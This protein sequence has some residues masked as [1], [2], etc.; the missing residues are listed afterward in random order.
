MDNT[1]L[2]NILNTC[3][4]VSLSFAILFFIITVILFFVFDIKTI[5]DI[6]TGRA[7]SKTVSEMKKANA[8]TGRLRVGGKTVTSKLSEED[9]RKSRTPA[10][11]PPDN[12]NQVVE[13]YD[14]GAAQTDVLKPEQ[15][16][17]AYTSKVT[18]IE[19]S[20]SETTVLNHTTEEFLN[21]EAVSS[22]EFDKSFKVIK[23]VVLINTDIMID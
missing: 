3:F 19:D 17:S 11:I 22:T 2:I 13:Q 16:D 20:Q 12:K 21:N 4:L 8:D 18:T 6:R 5:F 10:V 14:P 1:S 15:R 7:Q 9:K 23:S